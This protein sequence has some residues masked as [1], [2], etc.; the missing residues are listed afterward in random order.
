MTDDLYSKRM[1]EVDTRG[2][3][4]LG[5][6]E[7][8]L[9][10]Q[11]LREASGGIPEPVMREVVN[12]PDAVRTISF[13]AQE[14]RLQLLQRAQDSRNG[15]PARARELEQEYAASRAKEREEHARSKGRIR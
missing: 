8:N 10:V 15:D 12:D 6:A 4:K 2:K 5:E 13:A 7:W 9:R 14:S 11:R 1:T 3:E